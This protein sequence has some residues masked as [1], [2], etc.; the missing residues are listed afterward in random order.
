MCIWTIIGSPGGL[1]QPSKRQSS[2]IRMTNH[3]SADYDLRP[4]NRMS[5]EEDPSPA[6][7]SSA[8]RNSRLLKRWKRSIHI[9]FR[10]IWHIS[11]TIIFA[12]KSIFCFRISVGCFCLR[13]CFRYITCF[14]DGWFD[15]ALVLSVISCWLQ[16]PGPLTHQQTSEWP[17]IIL[18]ELQAVLAAVFSGC[19]FI[20][21]T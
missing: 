8:R 15:L 9:H 20:N 18:C 2:P 4:S 16:V 5:A 19:F 10:I 14:C 11:S 17:A 7:C 3:V 13:D 1:T 21:Q 12:N 6:R